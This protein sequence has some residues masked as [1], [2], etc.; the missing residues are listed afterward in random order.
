MTSVRILATVLSAG[1]LLLATPALAQADDHWGSAQVVAG[2]ERVKV[3]VTGTQYP[4]DR[5]NIDP[6]FGT[7]DTQ[8]I[9]MHPSGTM[10]IGNLK[11][12][13][14]EV[15]V[16]CPQ[17]GVISRTFVEVQPGNLVLDLQDRVYAAAG[18]SDKVSDP[19]LR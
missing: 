4:A 16:W 6:S 8:S 5:C 17:G 1:S 7:P 19:A 14:H 2:R 11:P 9:S 13:T 15:A 12:G 10:V 3:T 18:S